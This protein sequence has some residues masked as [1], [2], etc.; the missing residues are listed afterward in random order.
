MGWKAEPINP[1]SHT[2]M[3][4]ALV[5]YATTGCDSM[6]DARRRCYQKYRHDPK[7]CQEQLKDMDPQGDEDLESDEEEQE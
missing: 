7:L 6:D 2:D 1:L 5:Y 4:T 3:K